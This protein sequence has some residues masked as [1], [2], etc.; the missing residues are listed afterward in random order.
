[1]LT[2][3][4]GTVLTNSTW[5]WTLVWDFQVGPTSVLHLSAAASHMEQA[6][7]QVTISRFGRVTSCLS[8]RGRIDMQARTEEPQVTNSLLLICI[9]SCGETWSAQVQ[10]DLG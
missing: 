5:F 2:P 8:Q 6:Q 3:S 7:A 4:L 9:C 1:V 10:L